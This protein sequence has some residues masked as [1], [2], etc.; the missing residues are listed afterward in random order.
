MDLVINFKFF[1]FRRTI[2]ITKQWIQF[3]L[4]SAVILLSTMISFWGSSKIF[5]LLLVLTGGAIV[6]LALL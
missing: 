3:G 6:T 4:A 1:S 5:I 2:S